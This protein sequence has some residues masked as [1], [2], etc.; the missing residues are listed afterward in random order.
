[1]EGGQKRGLSAGRS[2][3]ASAYL[4][5]TSFSF[6]HLKKG[7]SWD[8]VHCDGPGEERSLKDVSLARGDGAGH[9]GGKD[10]ASKNFG[11][12]V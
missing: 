2:A 8:V 10:V 9:R 6:G 11:K 1:V 4:P 7:P 3:A 12:P 5:G